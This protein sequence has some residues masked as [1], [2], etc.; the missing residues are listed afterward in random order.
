MLIFGL[1]STS[2]DWLSNLSDE[3][4]L[5]CEKGPPKSSESEMLIFGLH[6]TSDDW[7]SDLSN[8]S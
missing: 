7:L 5:K 4:Q 6:S 3:S 1:H 8:E 2:D